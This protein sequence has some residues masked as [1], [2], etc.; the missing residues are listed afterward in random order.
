MSP[1]FALPLLVAGLLLTACGTEQ[2]VPAAPVAEVGP[3]IKDGS[4]MEPGR[5]QIA[6]LPSRAALGVKEVTWNMHW[7]ENGR[8]WAMYVNGIEVRSGELSSETPR[9]QQ[10]TVDVD[11]DKPGTYE[12]KVAL[13]NDHGCSESEP[14]V[15]SVSAG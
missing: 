13:C 9:Q 15:M 3:V 6:T 11:M 4:L 7:G 12:I 2:K 1:S 10:A 8:H 14:V 5:P